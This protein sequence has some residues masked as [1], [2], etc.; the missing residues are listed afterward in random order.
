MSDI[1]FL[2]DGNNWAHKHYHIA[3]EPGM[4]SGVENWL[5]AIET[6]YRPK[7]LAIAFDSAGTSWRRELY[8]AY[9]AQR[10][11]KAEDL[12]R[13]LVRLVDR[14]SVDWD[15]MQITGVEADDLIAS[16]CQHAVETGHRVVCC[17]SDKDLYQLLRANQVSQLISFR[18]LKGTITDVKYFSYDN[19]VQLFGFVPVQWPS[20]RALCGDKSDN[21][22]GVESIGTKA[23]GLLLQRFATVDDALLDPWNCPLSARQ[24]AKLRCAVQDGSFDAMLRICTLDRSIDLMEVAS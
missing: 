18:T 14:L 2:I 23:A 1:V 22:S 4:A 17:S 24:L 16:R 8:P 19:F 3:G 13:G 15:V 7:H 21:V 11:A 20:Y 5:R 9:K 12:E 10:A 6:Y